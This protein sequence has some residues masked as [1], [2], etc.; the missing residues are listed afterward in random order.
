MFPAYY[1]KNLDALFDVLTS[2]MTPIKM[3]IRYPD[4]ITANLGDYGEKLL[5]VFAQAAQAN[6][7][8]TLEMK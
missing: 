2:C 6:D 5:Q 7:N 3:I 4:S 1:G 8:I